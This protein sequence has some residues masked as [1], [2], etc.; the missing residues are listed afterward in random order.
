MTDTPR[1]GAI[2]ALLARVFASDRRCV[3]VL[4][5]LSLILVRFYVASGDISWSGDGSPCVA[6]PQRVPLT[7]FGRAPCHRPKCLGL[8]IRATLSTGC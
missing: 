8:A 3:W 4:L 7:R 5:G 1:I 6:L 2:T